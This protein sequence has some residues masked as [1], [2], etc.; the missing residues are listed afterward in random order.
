MLPTV[1]WKMRRKK[2]LKNKVTLFVFI[3]MLVIGLFGFSKGIL[4]AE[5]NDTYISAEYVRY[6]EI[7]GAKYNV[8]PELL[9]AII[10]TESSGKANVTNSSGTC[11][12]LMQVNANYQ[13][14]RMRKLGVNTLYDPYGNILVGTDLL[15]EYAMKYEDLALVLTAYN[16]GEYSKTF[17]NVQSTGTIPSY[18]QKIMNRAE[19]L[20]RVH[21]K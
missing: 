20:E 3:V 19:E 10:E 14:D 6:C 15:M 16:C 13:K 17:K 2:E 8:S 18:A 5:T 12:G 1:D 9:E 7:I 4:K 21:G 11:I